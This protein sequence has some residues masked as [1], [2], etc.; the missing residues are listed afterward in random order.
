[1]E[2]LS[3]K[4]TWRCCKC[5]AVK[6]MA[7]TDCLTRAKGYKGR[8]PALAT[9]THQRCQECRTIIPTSEK[10][11]GLVSKPSFVQS[12]F[13][14]NTVKAASVAELSTSKATPAEKAE[15]STPEPAPAKKKGWNLFG[16][17]VIKD[18]AVG[19]AETQAVK[20]LAAETPLARIPGDDM[21]PAFINKA[22]GLQGAVTMSEPG[23]LGK[24]GWLNKAKSEAVLGAKEGLSIPMPVSAAPAADSGR[25]TKVKSE[26]VL[27]AEEDSPLPEAAPIEKATSTVKK[28]WAWW[29]KSE[30]VPAAEETST[31]NVMMVDRDS[32]EA[33]P[34]RGP[35]F[36]TYTYTPYEPPKLELPE[37]LQHAWECCACNT[38]KLNRVDPSH[39][40]C[41]LL[42]K[43][44]GRPATHNNR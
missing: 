37:G 16:K 19:L 42:L 35:H 21:P 8:D 40:T 7:E 18:E 24:S 44:S 20:V 28:G 17:T 39:E 13:R 15:T 25:L 22:L 30:P 3:E 29:P 6:S 9:C 26:A 12:L 38:G 32:K 23:P 10:R 1:M 34:N 43:R 4:A 14:S 5:E 11:P 27:A 31:D 33:E 2:S 36:R 41:D